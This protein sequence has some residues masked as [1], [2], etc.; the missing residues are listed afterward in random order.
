MS[1]VSCTVSV[2]GILL[3]LSDNCCAYCVQKAAKLMMLAIMT[4]IIVVPG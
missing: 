4:K 2:F 3:F 1:L